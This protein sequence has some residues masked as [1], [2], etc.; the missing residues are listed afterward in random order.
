MVSV[1][2]EA[3]LGDSHL[4]VLRPDPIH[5]EMI[6]PKL[7]VLGLC[8]VFFGAV[9]ALSFLCQGGRNRWV[10]LGVT[11]TASSKGPMVFLL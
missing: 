1:F 8:Q 5:I 6:L 9:W 2:G 3:V 7:A 10:G 4:G 11:L